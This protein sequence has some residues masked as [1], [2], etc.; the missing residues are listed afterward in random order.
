[1][2]VSD[3]TGS[4]LA[5]SVGARWVWNDKKRQANRLLGG[6]QR[7]TALIGGSRSGKTAMIC[8]AIL[9]RALRAERSRHVILRLRGNAARAS[10]WLDTIPK[11]ARLCFPGVSMQDQRQDGFIR[12]PNRSEIWIGGLD[13][14]E[15]VEKILG[16]EYCSIY[17]NECS[18]IPY[19]SVQ[20]A[21]TRLAQMTE[22]RQRAY[23]D[24]N[25]VGRGHWTHRLFIERHDP[26]TRQPLIDPEDYRHVF[27]NP[28]DNQE[29]L[30]S[31]YLASLANMPERRRRRF[32]LGE[33]VDEIE[34]A[35]WTYELLERCR[36][37]PNEVPRDLKRVVVAV[38]PSGTDG[39]DELQA[40]DVGI[41]VVGL[42]PDNVAYVLA[43]LTC[44]LPPEGWGRRVAQAF[45][46]YKADAV[47][48][49]VNFGGDMVRS[50][51]Q[52][53]AQAVGLTVP[54]YTVRA[55][56]GK[57]IRAEPVSALY[58]DP[59]IELEPGVT[60]SAAKGLPCRVR[61]VWG[62][63]PETDFSRLEDELLQFSTMGYQ[64]TRSPNRGDSA[65]WGISHLLL[66][67]HLPALAAPVLVP[68]RSYQPEAGP[69]PQWEP[70]NPAAGQPAMTYEEYDRIVNARGW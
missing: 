53:A 67:D 12:L 18:Q 49:E 30:T 10:I 42:G 34:G 68:L 1:M 62:G 21:L 55:S 27:L 39:N 60:L 35:L 32:F 43:D 69:A 58:G 29:N 23:Y 5:P 13:S 38:D 28:L 2:V 15:R 37:T 50:T 52:V 70:A 40:D 11:V 45:E 48:A 36:C 7:H 65:I 56:R 9:T 33:Y 6:P 19:A 22:L 51:I 41:I 59:E 47:V 57:V 46:R 14:Q 24:L 66:N 17:L 4:A 31:E 54:I 8:R 44:Q 16:N 25:P 64:G 26:E 61:H 20:V 3:V 63:T